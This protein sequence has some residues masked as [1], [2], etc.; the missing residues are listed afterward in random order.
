[1]KKRLV[2]ILSILG[3]VFIGVIIAIV[4]MS[5]FGGKLDK[6]SKAYVDNIVPS[7]F[8]RWDV[9]KMMQNASPEFLATIKSPQDRARLED[10]FKACYERL[11]MLKQYNG[12]E[13]GAT[14][15]HEIGK[16]KTVYADYTARGTFENGQAKIVMRIIRKDNKWQIYSFNVISP[17][18]LNTALPKKQASPETP[19]KEDTSKKASDMKTVTVVEYTAMKRRDPF[20]PLIVK[21]EAK[22][23]SLIPIESYDVSEFKLIA[24][25]W[26]KTKYYAVITL[27]DGKSY[28]IREGIKLGLHGGKVYK[29]T[30]DSVI[31]REHLRD[32]KGVLSPKDTI[33]KLRREEE[34]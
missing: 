21:A 19:K 3:I 22:P 15:Y 27:P 10:L 20:I 18:L 31:I 29:I 12:S 23:K 33:L 4:M 11:G 34:G 13:G 2:L 28:T 30:K 17:V 16:G 9:S 8:G 1:M 25:L 5:Y 7:V 6:E 26:D 14:V 32:Y 24:I